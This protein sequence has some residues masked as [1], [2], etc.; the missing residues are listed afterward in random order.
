MIEDEYI[1]FCDV[2][3]SKIKCLTNRNYK[4]LQKRELKR[5]KSCISDSSRIGS[6][7][8]LLNGTNEAFYWIGFILAD[9]HIE[10]SKRLTINL[11]TK[12]LEH[13]KKLALFL[14]T[15]TWS[16]KEDKICCLSIQDKYV[17]E[18]LCEKYD[19]QSNKT[20]NPPKIDVFSNLV[21][22]SLLSIFAGFIDGDG[23]I[24]NL[25][26]RKDFNLR[27]KTHKSWIN[28]I[29]F[30]S[31]KFLE[32]ERTIINAQGYASLHCGDSRILKKLKQKILKLKLPILNRKWDII[33]MSYKGKYEIADKKKQSV[34]LMFNQGFK[35][36]DIALKI[37]LSQSRV[38]EIL[39]IYKN[40]NTNK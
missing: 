11:S 33:D 34:I 9:G 39:K 1:I 27:I 25:H 35:N 6:C 19:I 7:T 30:L 32:K 26:N 16:I 15:K 4:S 13:L 23:S 2:C 14:N 31:L 29:N 5:C 21:E 8:P 12:D 37:E 17:L 36:K 22:D 20:E 24:K 40:E 10:K 38:S 18:K 28:I 3:N